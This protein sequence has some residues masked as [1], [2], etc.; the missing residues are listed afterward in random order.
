MSFSR[1]IS[2]SKRKS[3]VRS[4]IGQAEIVTIYRAMLVYRTSLSESVTI[5]EEE[6]DNNISSEIA[7]CDKILDFWESQIPES[8]T[9]Q[10]RSDLFGDD[11]SEESQNSIVFVESEVE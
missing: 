2:R 10:I 11:D 1:R 3:A 7:S 6:C 4:A 5:S 8:V 9:S